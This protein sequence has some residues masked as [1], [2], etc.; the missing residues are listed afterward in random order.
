MTDPETCQDVAMPSGDPTAEIAATTVL[1]D[2]INR[3]RQLTRLDVQAGWHWHFG[4][5]PSDV[6]QQPEC[7]QAWAIAPLNARQHIAWAKGQQVL[8]LAQQFVVPEHLQGYE[9]RGLTL[10]LALTWWAE[11]AQIFLNGQL[12]QEGDLFDC[13]TRLLLQQAV[14]AGEQFSVVVRLV[15]PGHDDGALVR[16]VCLYEHPASTSPEADWQDPGFT[17]DELQVLQG[18]LTTF[19]PAQLTAL[20]ESVNQID[21]VSL[22]DRPTFERSLLH[23]HR[24]LQ[25]FSAAIKQ[26]RVRL[27]GHAHL[28]LAWLWP[29]RET[30]E[31]AERTFNSVLHLQQDFPELIFCHSSPALYAWIEQH[32]PQLFAAIQQQVAVGRW[33]VAA[34]LWV[35]PELNLIDGESLVRQ[36][37]YGQRYTQEKFGQ[38]SAI[39]WLPD[40]FGFCWQLPQIFK[41]GGIDYFVTQKLRWNDTTQFPYEVF[42]W[43]S[44]DGSEILSLMS[45]PI[46]EAI[47][48]VKIANYLWDW[49]AKTGI[50]EALWLPGV[51]DHGGGPTRDMLEI[52]QRWQASA[53]FPQLEFTTV[54]D[55]L[56]A[57]P[58]TQQAFQVKQKPQDCTEIANSQPCNSLPVWNDELYLEFH[59]GCY[60]THADQKRQNRRCENLLYQAELFAALATLTAEATYPKAALETA[61]KQILFNQFHDILPGSA[62]PAVFV[63]ANQ[64]WQEVEQVGTGILQDSLQAIATQIQLPDPPHPGSWAIVV[65][66]PLNWVRSQLIAVPLPDAENHWQVCDLSGKGLLCQRSGAS[67]LFRATEIPSVGYRVFWLCRSQEPMPTA[68]VPA[69]SL[70]L[71][72]E[73]SQL[74]VTVDVT[75]GDL[76][77]VFDKSQQREVLSGVGNQ[78]QAFHDRGQY[79]DAWNIDPNYAS[80]PLPPASL[81]K[82]EWIEWGTL[83][84]RLRVVRQIGQSQFC[85][86]YVLQAE[87]SLLKI[88][89]TV[90]WQESHVLVKVAFPLNW[91]ADFATYEIPCGAIA[92]PTRPH[93]PAE[94]AKWE[95]PALRWADLT[96]DDESYG[97][98]LLNDCKYG[99]D[100][101]PN[102]LRLTLLRS[103]RWPNPDADR[104][105]HEFTYA[106]YPHVGSWQ[107]AQ[108]VQ[109][110]YELNL[111]LQSV[112]LPPTD[113]SKTGTL[114]TVG[115]LLNLQAENLILKAFKQAE[116][117]PRQ[118]VLRCYEA[119]GKR[120]NLKLDSDLPIAIADCLNLL[121][122]PIETESA[123]QAGN[124]LEVS[125]WKIVTLAVKPIH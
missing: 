120:A 75:T 46:G 43:R 97:V 98:S 115:E 30:W 55:F 27:V 52:A 10:R 104:G 17:A 79:W 95:V 14:S 3:L 68:K 73:N 19:A 22:R 116:A 114:A 56:E 102:Q 51:G 110:G 89:T 117:D 42:W 13:S 96:S 63:D 90:D 109:Q 99:Y 76:A 18:Y 77:S 74:R 28:D 106:L 86:D 44:P 67:L 2:A 83:Q 69:D 93:T 82:I 61:W 84:Q 122:Q 62:I 58:T 8:W 94:Q 37:F 119:Y 31:A 70:P 87:S 103:A 60:T 9:L 124:A 15:S 100:S 121:E 36:V 65:F 33:E 29:I 40:S 81:Q 88:V 125:P 92:R 6:A 4:D 53:F 54:Q 7:W 16:S 101:Q 48:P 12:V 38:P 50:P 1:A 24:Q 105:Q 34:G 21:W 57:L 41:Q 64:A 5:L 26:R 118:W 66:N 47:D 25:P 23:L 123:F 72:L 112:C 78:L 111:P 80:Y 113:P 20:A 11:A 85:Q 71:V 108:T 45:A 35:E 107:T 39:A 49:Q 32:R 59:R 91:Q